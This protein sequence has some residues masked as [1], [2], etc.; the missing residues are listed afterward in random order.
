MGLAAGI[1]GAGAIG[2]VGSVAG[3]LI[4]ANAATTAAGE[5][6]TSAAN[7]LALQ[8]SMFNTGTQAVQ[9][10]VNAGTSA[11]PQLQALLTP[12]S[13]SANAILQNPGLQFQTS[14][15]DLGV[16]NALAAEGLAG[17]NPNGKSISS[18]LGVGLSNY[19]QGLGSSYYQNAVNNL[20]NL[21]NTGAGSANSILSGS[22]NSGNAMAQ[23]QQNIGN[24][25]A[26]GTLGAGNAIAGGLTGST[27]SA[28]NALLLSSILGGAGGGSGLYG[29]LGSGVSAIQNS[30]AL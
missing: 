12:G 30:Y 13:T 19:N 16:T 18:S 9:P 8:K 3:G 23:T 20:Q 6:A 5:Q 14:Y 1:I 15:G 4:N 10:F 7:A 28:G 21:V 27:G 26:S 11:L 2:A 17:S 22:I 29:A 24:A 25:Q